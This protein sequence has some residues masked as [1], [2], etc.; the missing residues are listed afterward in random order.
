MFPPATVHQCNLETAVGCALTQQV[1]NFKANKL[2]AHVHFLLQTSG[3]LPF[4]GSMPNVSYTPL[5]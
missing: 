3:Q 1:R 4:L 2:N 5:P